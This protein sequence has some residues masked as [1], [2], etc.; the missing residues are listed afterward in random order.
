[1]SPSRNQFGS[2]FQYQTFEQPFKYENFDWRRCQCT[3]HPVVPS[4]QINFSPRYTDISL[5]SGQAEE[6]HAV[7][8]E[9]A[10]A[11]EVEPG[12][13]EVP[14]VEENLHDNGECYMAGI[15]IG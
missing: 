4:E 15:N 2:V 9:E 7:E 13:E 14:L 1:M 12:E 6:D 10:A 8:G 5:Q 11:R 3:D